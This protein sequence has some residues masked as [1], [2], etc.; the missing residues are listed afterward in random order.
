MRHPRLQKG[1][2]LL[3][4]GIVVPVLM[5]VLLGASDFGRLS[6]TSILL[7]GAAHAG[8]RFGTMTITNA[9]DTEG[10]K[11]A[12]T[13]DLGSTSVGRDFDITVERFCTCAPDDS[14]IACDN[15][16]PPVP[17]H[18]SAPRVYLRVGVSSSFD[19]LFA[20]PGIP[21]SVL[22]AR[23]AQMRVD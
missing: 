22:V 11:K 6:Y 21:K 7:A 10:I 5:L 3:E 1:A 2:A 19:T 17:G 4:T 16:C 9:T 12:V 14:S 13:D 8:A 23:Q 18:S 20:Y 15:V